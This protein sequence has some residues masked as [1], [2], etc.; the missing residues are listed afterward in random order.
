MDGN[1]MDNN[2][3]KIKKDKNWLLKRIKDNN[4]AISDIFLLLYN[5]GV[6]TIYEKKYKTSG[7]VLE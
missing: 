1:I 4:Y 6:I 7:N 5:N 2:L 3:R